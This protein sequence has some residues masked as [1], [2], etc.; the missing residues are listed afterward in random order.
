MSMLQ[1]IP[2][3]I[4]NKYT[5]SALGFLLWISFFDD[6]DLITNFHHS[7][8]LKALE[9]SRAH[10]SQKIQETQA[11]LNQ[12]KDNPRTLEKYAREKYRMKRANEDLFIVSE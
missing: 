4:K 3:W 9:R 5:L 12:L 1:Y 8:E 2:A 11:E 6:R 7:R 10:F